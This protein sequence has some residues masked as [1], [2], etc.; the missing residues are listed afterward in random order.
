MLQ[1]RCW[2]MSVVREAATMMSAT[3]SRMAAL[4]DTRT[5]GAI[6]IL[7]L[8]LLRAVVCTS[9]SN[10]PATLAAACCSNLKS[11]S[12]GRSRL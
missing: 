4:A 8:T 6:Q 2:V 5:N 12:S 1:S 11:R 9:G 10:A 7:M 3:K